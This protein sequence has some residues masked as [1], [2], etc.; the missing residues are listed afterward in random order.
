MTLTLMIFHYRM[1][2][3]GTLLGGLSVSSITN[4]TLND[5][6]VATTYFVYVAKTLGSL[7]RHG[8]SR[9]V[10][11]TQTSLNVQARLHTSTSAPLRADN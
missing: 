3:G 2:T 1:K 11:A 5:N 9:T 10:P 6:T 4:L 8:Q 7:E